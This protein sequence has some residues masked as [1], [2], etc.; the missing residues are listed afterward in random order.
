MRPQ[1]HPQVVFCRLSPLQLRLYEFFLNSKPVQQL[2]SS[3]APIETGCSAGA[4]SGG[5]RGAGAR[6][7]RG[8]SGGGGGAPSG[9]AAKAPRQPKEETLAPLAAITALKKL[10]CRESA[11]GR[12]V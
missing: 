7:G 6:S 4:A 9:G 1:L 10:C 8:K 12:T 5:G 3:T 11:S 2:L